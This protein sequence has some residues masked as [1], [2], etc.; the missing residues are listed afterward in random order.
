MR[1]RGII[2]QT[3]KKFSKKI[4]D[5]LAQIP[6]YSWNRSPRFDD[7]IL[8]L[9]SAF[10]A[11][12]WPDEDKIDFLFT[13]LRGTARNFFRVSLNATQYRQKTTRMLKK[14]STIDFTATSLR[15]GIFRNGKTL[16]ALPSYSCN[17]NSSY[18]E[19]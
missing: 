3:K 5:I 16:L 12:Q 18:S 4:V 2:L 19:I 17:C 14:P 13:K 8:N 6:N 15:I 11:L 7:W 9:D 1:D 10:F